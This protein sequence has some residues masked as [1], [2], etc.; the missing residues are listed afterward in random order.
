MSKIT[1]AVDA[2]GGD[3]G[4]IVTVPAVAMAL[5]RREALR[6]ILVGE[7]AALQPVLRQHGLLDHPR[8]MLRHASEQVAMDEPPALALRNKKDSSMRV[9]IELVKAGEAG[10]CVSGG[11]TGALMAIARFVL[12]MIP[13]I[14]RPAIISSLPT[15]QLGKSVQMLDLGA[16]VDATPDHLCQFAV[17]GSVYAA[18]V[19]GIARPSIGLLNIGAEDI[20]GNELVKAT[21]EK[22]M[23]YK[24]QIHYVGYVEGDDIYKGTVDVVVCDGFVGNVVLKASEGIACMMAGY[25]KAEFSQGGWQRVLGLLV[26]TSLKRAMQR[27]DPVH[28]NGASLLGLQGIVIK[29]HGNA[30]REA[31]VNA[32]NRAADHAAQAIPQLINR[33]VEHLLQDRV[34]C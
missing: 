3:H 32:I 17:M 19:M 14:D 21:A 24:D 20:K 12:K 7:Q 25:I 18:A 28:Y 9:A 34:K 27:V 8:M 33:Q 26:K 2:M 30:Q 16:N 29:S 11:N 23:Q 13:G 22:L 1:I 10:A 5:Q 15:T 6:I 31:F 4:P